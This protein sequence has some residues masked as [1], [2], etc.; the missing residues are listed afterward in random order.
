[1]RLLGAMTVTAALLAGTAATAHGA[2][3]EERHGE[4][5]VVYGHGAAD[6]AYD[7]AKV[8]LL[9]AC[10]LTL[11]CTDIVRRN[12]A[13]HG[14]IAKPEAP[15]IRLGF[16]NGFWSKGPDGAWQNQPKDQVAGATE[17]GHYVKTGTFVTGH[18]DAI[19][20]VFGVGLEVRP[21]ADP[22]ALTIG[23]TLPVEVLPDGKP[24][25][26]AELTVDY[27]NNG[28][29]AP[30]VVGADG[31]ADVPI[32]SA[33]LTVIVAFLTTPPMDAALADEMGHAASLAFALAHGPE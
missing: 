28:D 21:L 33:G 23:G 26:G 32:A 12:G 10:S 14:A 7:P 31:R 2:W 17:S 25:V 8:T 29:A 6:D 15:L 9:Q 1:M 20:A 18:L 3:V 22:M 11:D 27:L 4:L 13:E 19:P 16:D 5:Y 30:I 24:A